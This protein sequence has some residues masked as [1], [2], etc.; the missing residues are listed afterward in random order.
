[1]FK[2]STEAMGYSSVLYTDGEVTDAAAGLYSLL[3]VHK[4][5]ENN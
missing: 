2:H 1:M 3:W 4:F 5:Q